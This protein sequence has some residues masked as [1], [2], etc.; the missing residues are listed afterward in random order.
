MSALLISI[1]SFAGSTFPIFYP[2]LSLPAL[3]PMLDSLFSCLGQEKLVPNFS[4]QKAN[5]IP[6]T[7]LKQDH[8]AQLFSL[9]FQANY[10]ERALINFF[11]PPAKKLPLWPFNYW[12]CRF[13]SHLFPIYFSPHFT[14]SWQLRFLNPPSTVV[15]H[16]T[17]ASEIT[18][19]LVTG[20]IKW[21]TTGSSICSCSSLGLNQY[22]K[23]LPW[24]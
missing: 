19:K 23:L 1:I 17:R 16:E 6:F 4:K 15:P 21:T 24:L 11:F 3:V 12:L 18:W 14:W 2:P 5:I 10:G 8:P 9:C 22:I 20:S 7:P 13:S